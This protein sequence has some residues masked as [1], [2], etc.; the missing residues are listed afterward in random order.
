MLNQAKRKAWREFTSTTEPHSAFRLARIS[1]RMCL[2]ALVPYLESFVMGKKTY[3]TTHQMGR[4]F[5]DH[6][7]PDTY[8]HL[9][10][11]V[12]EPHPTTA[13]EKYSCPQ[14]LGEGEVGRLIDRLKVRRAA[15]SDRVANELLKWTKEHH[16]AI[17]GA[18]LQ[19]LYCSQV[20]YPI[21][22]R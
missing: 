4:I 21:S 7:W 1:K 16:P 13:R 18:P 10:T 15:G 19:G 22:S 17:F 9:A 6:L 5:R 11:P 12:P 2:P 8:D 14:E 3:N 20:T